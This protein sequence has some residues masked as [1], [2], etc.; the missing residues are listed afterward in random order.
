MPRVQRDPRD[1]PE[2]VAV[3][4]WR[5][6]L[7]A[8]CVAFTLAN[9]WG[10]LQPMVVGRFN[11]GDAVFPAIVLLAT[12]GRRPTV[13]RGPRER[14]AWSIFA[15]VGISVALFS[16]SGYLHVADGLADVWAIVLVAV[17]EEL[18]FRV[19][20]PLLFLAAGSVLGMRRWPSLAVGILVSSGLFAIMPGHTEQ[21][22]GLLGTGVFFGTGVAL[23]LLVWRTGK[24]WPAI[25]VHFVVDALTLLVVLQ[26]G[27]IPVRNAGI[28]VVFGAY[29]WA[30]RQGARDAIDAQA[31]QTAV[32]M[33]A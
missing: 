4:W 16:A 1:I 14:R 24:L 6:I 20:I 27:A 29:L 28:I 11:I 19:A 2:L 32:G 8:G 9:A 23:G 31:S 12:L 21:G 3:T 7:A 22:F 13:E 5:L 15:L 25:L 26:V 18:T 17:S 10:G 30:Y 33:A